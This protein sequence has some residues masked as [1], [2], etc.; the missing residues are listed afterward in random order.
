MGKFYKG[1]SV[2]VVYD[3]LYPSI[4]KMLYN[5]NVLSFP[6]GTD[7]NDIFDKKALDTLKFTW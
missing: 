5:V 7:M 4:C 6:Y 1:S 3:S 2:L